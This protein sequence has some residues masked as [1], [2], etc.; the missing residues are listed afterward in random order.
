MNA[1]QAHGLRARAPPAATLAAQDKQDDNT[2][3]DPL[4]A[5]IFGPM[6]TGGRRILQAAVL[7]ELSTT[8]VATRR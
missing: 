8:P 5:A 1:G 2:V 7:L 6:T 3:V 4:S